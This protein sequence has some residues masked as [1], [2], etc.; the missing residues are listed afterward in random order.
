MDPAEP[1]GLDRLEW[2][3]RDELGVYA[4]IT[5]VDV[6]NDSDDDAWGFGDGRGWSCGERVWIDADR[7]GLKGGSGD[8]G[9][10][11]LLSDDCPTDSPEEGQ[12]LP[13]HNSLHLRVALLVGYALW[14]A[15]AFVTYLENDL[16][17]ARAASTRKRR[18]PRK[19]NALRR[20]ATGEAARHKKAR[21][22]AAVAPPDG[23]AQQIVQ[24]QAACW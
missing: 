12:A 5:S 23:R 15:S 20:R 16:W 4:G 9:T 2:K 24:N 18:T 1:G 19:R 3:G 10:G 21:S 6:S 8:D 17:D 22:W 11:D 7:A 13:C 14:V